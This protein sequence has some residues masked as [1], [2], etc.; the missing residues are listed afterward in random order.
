ME[1][2]KYK[3]CPSCGEHNRPTSL[4]CRKCETDLT[5]V[6]MVDSEMEQREL[7]KESDKVQ[8][9]DITNDAQ[10][11]RVCEEC[12][13]ENP[14]QARKCKHCGE[15]ISDILP[16]PASKKEDIT[17][18]YELK[19]V[20]GVF[21][22]RIEKA[23]SVIGREADLK[24]YLGTKLYVS[25]QH[26]ELTVVAGKV[27][28]KNLSGTNKTFVNNEEVSNDEPYVLVNGDEIGLGGKMIADNRQ[29]NAAYFLFQG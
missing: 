6:R 15:E 11:V 13:T 27:F 14:P 19:S 28:I 18:S 8:S 16:K 25:R 12:G 23:V 17:Y 24:E 9:E 26:A 22:T 5:G 7:E 1:L 3:V 21:S 10:L 4:E 29:D 20:D 2:K